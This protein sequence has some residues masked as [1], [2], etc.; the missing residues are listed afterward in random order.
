VAL[1][2]GPLYHLTESHE[3]LDALRE[4]FRMLRHGGLIFAAAINRFA[5]LYDGLSR[6]R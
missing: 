2:L 3:R 5:S 4:A 1:L 6:D